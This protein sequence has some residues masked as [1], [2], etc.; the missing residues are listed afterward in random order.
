MLRRAVGEHRRWITQPIDDAIISNIN[1]R[2]LREHVGNIADVSPMCLRHFE[3]W[4]TKVHRYVYQYDI[5]PKVLGDETSGE[6]FY[7]CIDICL[8]ILVKHG[9]H[10]PNYWRLGAL[11]W[12]C[13]NLCIAKAS[14]CLKSVV[15]P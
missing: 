5:S 6:N 9:D 1:R 13:P 14:G 15:V 8:D 4:C 3:P 11:H 12:R 10:L 7:A 2:C